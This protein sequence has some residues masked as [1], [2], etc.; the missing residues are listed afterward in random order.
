[1]DPRERTDISETKKSTVAALD[2]WLDRTTAG[3]TVTE[4]DAATTDVRERLNALGYVGGSS[5]RTRRDSL[6][7]PKDTIA[8][9]E[10]LKRAE[11]LTN[12]GRDREAIEAIQRLVAL[13]P[14][15]L[16]AWESLAKILVK[17]GRTREAVAAFSKVLDLDPLKPETHLALARIFALEHQPARAR[18]HAE[19]ALKRDP[20]AANEILA[21]LTLD[22]GRPSDARAFGQ[23]SVAVDPSRYMSHFLLGEI[24]R[25]QDRCDEAIGNYQKAI[26]AKATEPHAIVRNL[27]A[28]LADCLARS[29]READAEREFKEEL[30]AIAWSPEGRTGLATLYR[31]QGRDAEARAVL[32]G[33][34]DAAP[35]AD[36]EMYWT[37]VHTFTVLGDTTAA[38]AWAA[39]A[40]TKF[41]R[42]PRFR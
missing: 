38:G 28:G 2:A 30:A 10:E 4:P 1:M 17:N 9:Y 5:P 31:S 29:G 24:A 8:E 22:A 35:R 14:R 32:G 16:D 36:A 6:P 19:L 37:V 42:D 34:V 41:P 21:E 39:K 13:N 25:R 12:S 27:H 20:A 11:A 23:H 26:A 33:I 15:M 18:E 7:D 40:R 3:T